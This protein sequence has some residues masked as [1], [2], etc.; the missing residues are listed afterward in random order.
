MIQETKRSNNLLKLLFVT[1]ALLTCTFAVSAG[2]VTIPNE[3]ATGDTLTAGALNDN[4]TAFKTAVDDNDTRTSTLETQNTG[5]AAGCGAGT[6][7]RSVD[8]NG[9]PICDA[10]IDT[11]TNSNAATIC[12]TGEYL[13]GDGSCYQKRPYK[14]D[15]S[16]VASATRTI[17]IGTGERGITFHMTMGNLNTAN[18]YVYITCMGQEGNSYAGCFAWGPGNTSATSFLLRTGY[19]NDVLTTTRGTISE[20][21]AVG[22][23]IIKN[24]T[25]STIYYS[26]IVEPSYTNPN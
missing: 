26:V 11:D 18:A 9:N 21:G 17:N 8:A 1:G 20:G 10:D 23:F 24:N 4:N 3:F 5:L 13:N 19:T 2:P 7:L 22:S 12:T 14:I 25:A 15:G 6:Y 16:L